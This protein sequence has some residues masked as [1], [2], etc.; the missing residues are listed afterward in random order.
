MASPAPKSPEQSE[1]S[2]K[3]DRQLR[4]WN[5]HGQALLE[6]AH[7]CLIN[8]NAVGTEIM[9]S[10]VLP[11]IG[12]FTIIDGH[13]VK[14]EDIGSNFFLDSDSL[15]KSRA[16]VTTQLLL[17]MNSDVRGDFIDEGP[18]QILIN[19]PDFFNNFSLV[20][21][22]AMPEKS[23]VVLSR[24]LWELDI[25][26][27]A[28]RTIGFV[29]HIRVQVKEHTVVETHPDNEKSDL[30]LD[31]PFEALKKHFDAIDV[32]NGSGVGAR[33]EGGRGRVA[34]IAHRAQWAKINEGIACR[35]KSHERIGARSSPESRRK[36]AKEKARRASI[37]TYV[38]VN[39]SFHDMHAL[40]S[41]ATAQHEGYAGSRARDDEHELPACVSTVYET[42]L[43]AAREETESSR[44]DRE[45]IKK[46]GSRVRCCSWPTTSFFLCVRASRAKPKRKTHERE[47]QQRRNSI[48]WKATY[49]HCLARNI[50]HVRTRSHI[51]TRVSEYSVDVS[52]ESSGRDDVLSQRD[53]P[54]REKMYMYEQ[55]REEYFVE[56]VHHV[57]ASIREKKKKKRVRRRKKNK[58]TRKTCFDVNKLVREIVLA[59]YFARWELP[60]HRVKARTFEDIS[61]NENTSLLQKDGPVLKKKELPKSEETI[62]GLA[63]S[64]GTSISQIADP[65]T[66]K[67]MGTDEQT[68]SAKNKKTG[69]E[70]SPV[71]K[72]ELSNKNVTKP[73]SPISI[74]SSA[75]LVNTEKDPKVIN[76]TAPVELKK[77][78]VGWLQVVDQRF[79]RFWILCLVHNGKGKGTQSSPQICG[80]FQKKNIRTSVHAKFF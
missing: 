29:G 64:S 26:L 80:Q 11:G 49:C 73:I 58:R 51:Y 13:K 50:S 78:L 48:T 69:D 55:K 62:S 8:A 63:G 44:H 4:L 39:F 70:A 79:Y 25:P 3:Y 61:A 27:I 60:C 34:A 71:K 57:V 28:C 14:D 33:D 77:K 2:R 23:L 22:C 66:G 24:K 74:H 1:K 5:D 31:K 20:I 42:M 18:E 45:M 19:S 43:G 46:I 32:E 65:I 41:L 47:R 52:S 7:I 53:R 54:V 56:P 38:A 72:D 67:V 75:Q 10:L 59:C 68:T 9:K 35:N 12:A 6:S 76:L 17:E 16:Q 30:R 37:P 15:G 40:V 36:L 21:A